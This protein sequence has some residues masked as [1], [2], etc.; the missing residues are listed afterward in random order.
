MK[1]WGDAATAYGNAARAFAR[2]DR[3]ADAR[4]AATEGLDALARSTRPNPST[5]QRL[6]KILAESPA[7][8]S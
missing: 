6:Q 4:A 8:R 2:A 3:F 5:L 7:E 1:K